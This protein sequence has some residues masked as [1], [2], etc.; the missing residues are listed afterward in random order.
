MLMFSLLK[1]CV[2]SVSQAV[3]SSVDTALVPLSG[4]HRQRREPIV[5]VILYKSEA[6][7]IEAGESLSVHSQRRSESREKFG[8]PEQG[9]KNFI[10]LSQPVP[11]LGSK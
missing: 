2:L 6:R 4:I 8:T 11:G 5:P 7:Q 10:L 1:P 9:I 3:E